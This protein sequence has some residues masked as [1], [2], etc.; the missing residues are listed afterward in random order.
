LCNFVVEECEAKVTE[1]DAGLAKIIKKLK[2]FSSLKVAHE[3]QN[4]LK[5]IITKQL[6]I[7]R[8]FSHPGL[9]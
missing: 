5:E 9:K 8:I 4:D 7:I 2:N 3:L 6:A 1:I